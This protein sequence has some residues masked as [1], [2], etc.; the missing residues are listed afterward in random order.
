[1]VEGI[2]GGLIGDTTAD[3]VINSTD[4]DQVKSQLRLSGS[5]IPATTTDSLLGRSGVFRRGTGT[6]SAA[7]GRGARRMNERTGCL[8]CCWGETPSSRRI[9]SRHLRVG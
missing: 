4:V 7:G 6:G 5:A 2:M 8:T 9:S 1:D 3:G